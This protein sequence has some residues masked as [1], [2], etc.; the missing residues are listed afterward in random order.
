[1]YSEV[2][3]FLKKQPNIFTYYKTIV[4]LNAVLTLTENHLVYGRKSFADQF[5]PMQV[6]SKN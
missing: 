1:M 3:T 6:Q 5:N 4:T 2:R